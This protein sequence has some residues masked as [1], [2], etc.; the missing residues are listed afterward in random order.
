MEIRASR[1]EES[2]IPNVAKPSTVTNDNSGKSASS[3]K[4]ATS[5]AS[6]QKVIRNID[7]ALAPA[8]LSYLQHN[9]FSASASAMRKDMGSRKRLLETG[10]GELSAAR[11]KKLARTADWY[12]KQEREWQE[13][14]QIK[15]DYREERLFNVWHK[16]QA[17]SQASSDSSFLESEDALWA[18]RIRVRYF[19]KIFR[20]SLLKGDSGTDAASKK[21]LLLPDLVSDADFKRLILDEADLLPITAEGCIY[22]APSVLLAIGRNLQAQHGQSPNPVVQQEVQKALSY[23]VYD[24]MSDLPQEMLNAISSSSCAEEAEKL[25]KAI[26]SEITESRVPLHEC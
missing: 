23:M 21:N 6:P 8:V 22:D 5:P 20:E 7:G 18:C 17:M 13:L 2:C 14:Q 9:G 11:A 16:L 10:F 12:E 15:G 25:L 19:Y 1:N 24:R 3:K 4:L 26:R